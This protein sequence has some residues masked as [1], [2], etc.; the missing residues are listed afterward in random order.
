[1]KP[2]THTVE[3]R[4]ND[5]GEAKWINNHLLQDWLKSWPGKDVTAKFSIARS[6]SQDRLRRYY[7]GEVVRKMQMGLRQL[8]YNLDTE[9]THQFCKQISPIMEQEIEVNG[10]YLKRYRSLTDDDFTK[11]DFFEYISDIK[12]FA[13]EQLSVIINDPGEY[14]DWINEPIHEEE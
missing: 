14:G 10:N 9:A 7:F 1:M 2:R 11:S 13:A 6:G 4:V 5:K 8:G 3:I 12:Q